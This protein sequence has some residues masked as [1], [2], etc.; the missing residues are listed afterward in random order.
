[1]TMPTPRVLLFGDGPLDLEASFQRLNRIAKSHS[2]LARFL[3]KATTLLQ[4]ELVG[5]TAAEKM[6]IGDVP[7]LLE[8]AQHER[9]IPDATVHAALSV[10]AQISELLM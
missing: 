10:S 6:R 1:M 4:D 2:Q 5:L 8:L 9:S 3:S 7:S